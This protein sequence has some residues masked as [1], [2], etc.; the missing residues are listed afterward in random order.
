MSAPDRAA[1]GGAAAWLGFLSAVHPLHTID[2]PAARQVSF[3][4]FFMAIP[5][6]VLR[7]RLY[8]LLRKDSMQA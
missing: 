8:P 7:A 3:T 6:L 2:T 4:L 1:A 5:Y